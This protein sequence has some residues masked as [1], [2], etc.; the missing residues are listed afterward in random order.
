MKQNK[1]AS[2]TQERLDALID[3]ADG[4]CMICKVPLPNLAHTCYG[5]RGKKLLLTGTCCAG[6]LDPI[7]SIGVFCNDYQAVTPADYARAFSTHPFQALV[8]RKK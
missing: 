1:R 3:E 4:R 7:V 2:L 5:F 6:K 8:S